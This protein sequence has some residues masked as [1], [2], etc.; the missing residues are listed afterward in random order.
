M[1][2]LV[3]VLGAVL[4]GRTMAMDVK[5]KPCVLCGEDCGDRPRV[6]DVHGRYACR[7]C[8]E[9]RALQR[10]A[11]DETVADEPAIEDDDR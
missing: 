4:G 8:V 11:N 9:K 1:A 5:P 7:A 6:K 10:A 3:A 2:V